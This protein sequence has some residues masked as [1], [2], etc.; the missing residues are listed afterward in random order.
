MAD[1]A[2]VFAPTHRLEG[3]AICTSSVSDET[4]HRNLAGVAQRFLRVG[5]PEGSFWKQLGGGAERLGGWLSAPWGR[6]EERG[7]DGIQEERERLVELM[8]RLKTMQ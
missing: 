5:H 4:L 6:R 7:G 8:K 3:G 2:E 1:S